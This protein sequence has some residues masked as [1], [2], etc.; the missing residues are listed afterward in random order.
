MAG[1]GGAG[2]KIALARREF[3]LVAAIFGL[4]YLNHGVV[5]TYLL[6]ILTDRGAGM[7]MAVAAAA[8]IGPAQVAGRL[9]LMLSGG[10]VTT[11]W[12]VRACILW[13]SLAGFVLWLAGAAVWLVFVFAL[14]QGGAMGMVS[15]LRPVL[16]A[17]VLG[18]QSFGAIS[19]AIAM[20]PLLAGAAAPFLGAGLIGWLGVPGS[21]AAAVGM[22]WLAFGAALVLRAL[23]PGRA[24]VN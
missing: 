23:E 3:W 4:L 15:I 5:I 21:L 17:E 9:V 18:R 8:C 2:L 6:P 11:G 24:G 20:A 12:T 1:V 14:L 22:G 10:R 7:G 19:G 16:T 13:I